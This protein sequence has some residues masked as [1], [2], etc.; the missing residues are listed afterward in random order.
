MKPVRVSQLNAYVRRVLSS[1]PILGNL[2]VVGEVSNFKLHSNG[3]V[4]FSLKDEKAKVNC[5][6]PGDVYAG[7]SCAIGDGVEVIATGYISVYERGGT[8]SLN[9]RALDV[10]GSG[11]LAMAFE[12]LKAKLAGEGLFDPAQ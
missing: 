10:S 5:F 6:L 7:L 1:D 3:H 11:D 12:R 9:V 8:Y 4:Y 2:S